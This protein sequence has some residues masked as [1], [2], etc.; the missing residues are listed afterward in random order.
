M[1]VGESTG[2][3]STVRV[4]ICITVGT[5]N[6]KSENQKSLTK[7]SSRVVET[8]AILL[9]IQ[10]RFMLDQPLSDINFKNKMA[11]VRTTLNSC[12]LI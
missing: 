6:H 8:L 5:K 11:W 3:S 1:M 9:Q 12:A 10:G 7:V 4:L 2:N